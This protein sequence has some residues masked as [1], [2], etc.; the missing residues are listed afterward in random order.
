[1]SRKQVKGDKTEELEI[2]GVTKP[3]GTG[4]T[5]VARDKKCDK[6]G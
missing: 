1:M 6:T 4:A 5:K 3:A 2:R